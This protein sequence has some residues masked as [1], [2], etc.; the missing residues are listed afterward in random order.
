MKKPFT[1]KGL[2]DEWIAKRDELMTDNMT[3]E[4]IE[5]IE[6]INRCFGLHLSPAEIERE[7]A[8]ADATWEFIRMTPRT[9]EDRD[10]D[11]PQNPFRGYH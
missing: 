9:A 6:R 8:L 4:E 1:V 7:N 3:E 11:E 2:Q 5:H 10:H